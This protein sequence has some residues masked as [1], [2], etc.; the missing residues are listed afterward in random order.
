VRGQEDGARAHVVAAGFQLA[1]RP[2]LDLGH[3]RPAQHLSAFVFDRLGERDQVRARIELRLRLEAQRAGHRERQRHVAHELRAQADLGH[4]GGLLGQADQLERLLGVEIT[5]HALEAAR[6]A[7]A[8]DRG[9]DEV[10]RRRARLCHRARERPPVGREERVV[11][12]VQARGEVAGAVAARA[13]AHVTGLQHRDVHAVARQEPRRGEP[14]DAGADDDHGRG[15]IARERRVGRRERAVGPR[16]ARGGLSDPVRHAPGVLPIVCHT[17]VCC[18][19]AFPG[20]KRGL[21]G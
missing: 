19:S 21:L 18:R 10:D 11:V 13:G 4:R 5:G 8:S 12:G 20:G 15:E 17:E 14:G 1:G 7:Q 2:V 16:R 6:D 9:L 3:A